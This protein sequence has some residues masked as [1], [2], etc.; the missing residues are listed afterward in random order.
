MAVFKSFKAIRPKAENASKVAALPY[1][2]MNSEEARQV[3]KKS[4]AS[5]YQTEFVFRKKSRVFI[6]INKLWMAAVKP[7]LLA[8]LQLTIIS[9]M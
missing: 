5:W 7:A 2:V 3:L 8:A 4:L 9:I 1:D 6:S